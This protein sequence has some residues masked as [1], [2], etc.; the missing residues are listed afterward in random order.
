[1]VQKKK[2][3]RQT[4]RQTRLVYTYKNRREKRERKISRCEK[5]KGKKNHATTKVKLEGRMDQSKKLSSPNPGK[6]N[7]DSVDARYISSES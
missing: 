5:E 3:D 1:M 7:W 2:T 4:Y 6:D